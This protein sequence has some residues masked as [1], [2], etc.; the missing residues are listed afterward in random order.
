MQATVSDQTGASV[1]CTFNVV[2]NAAPSTLSID[3]NT[4]Q[5]IVTTLS[6]GQTSA[7][8]SYSVSASGGFPPYNFQYNPPS[9]TSFEVGTR[10][11]QATVTDQAGRS[12]SCN[13]AVT[14]NSAPVALSI[15]QNSCQ[16][17]AT[18]LSAGQ[19]STVVSYSV[20]ASGGSP[21]Y[22]FQ[23]NPP[24]GTSFGVG[25]RTVQATVSDQT[26]V[27]VSCTFN[28]VVNAAPSTLSIDQNTCQNI[29]TTLSSGQTSIA[30]SYSVSASGGSPPY[31]FQ[32]NPSSGTSFGV[33]TRTVQATVT[34]Q[35][36][37][38]VSCS[39]AVTVNSAPVALSIDQNSCQNIA[40]TL[41][42]GQT[43]TLVSYSVSAAG[44]SPPYNFQYNPPSG[45]SFGVG[46]G[47]VQ[48]TVTDQT[49][50]SVSCTFNVVVTAALS[51]DQNSCQNIVT[52]IAAGQT[53]AAVSY[54][55]SASGGSPPYNFQ[56]NPPSGTSFG[57]GTRNVQATVTDQTGASVSC[58]FVVTVNSAPVAL[59][60]DQNSC[61][62]IATTLSAGQT[63]AVVS[64]SVS[65]SGGSPP[66]NFQYNPP[67]GTSFGVGTRTV[68][69]TVSDQTG[70]SVSCTFNVVVTAALSIDQNSC[71]NI[72]T[73]IAAGQTSTVVSYSVS[74][75]GGSPPYNFQYNPPSG[76]SFG[77]G[78]RNV[79][80][81]VTDQTGASVSCTFVVTVNSA[82]STLSIDQNTCQDIV[83]TLSAGQ[84]S[85][86]VQYS[87][88]ASGGS[89]PY[90]FQY[91]P[92]SGTIYGVGTSTVLATVT[93]Q[94]GGSV[95]CTFVITV[96]AAPV[97][98]YILSSCRFN[99]FHFIQENIQG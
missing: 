43:S 78:T 84:T 45:S 62:N 51:I 31:N 13:F 49:G 24:S 93:D 75:S 30:V 26:G 21:P 42:A 35:G 18:T 76:T 68:Q 40:T 1:S 32:Y 9:G 37:G 19:I 53:S 89:P 41:S 60:I 85:I 87:V 59:S 66:Y 11:V 74:V 86:A 15:D 27:S 34:D 46:T 63:S 10:T 14:V 64:Y 7:V 95:T 92:P 80:A 81:T 16:N 2:V 44:G 90:S 82:P 55:V 88:T 61:Q 71:Q 54:S 3:Q 38:S 28:V 33:G 17:I 65:A 50:A 29:V 12:V 67:S 91:S 73:T 8:V 98:K 36:G 94:A 99:S 6:S 56:Y 4:C 79:Q 25:T 20:S 48:A 70:A 22:N 69:A 83:T 39:F 52:T 96:N 47:T 23:Y 58:S 72:V 5:N 77:V 97:G 57:V